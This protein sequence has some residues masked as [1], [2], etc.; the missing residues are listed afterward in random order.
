MQTQPLV[1]L[2]DS[3]ERH[4]A[5]AILRTCVHCGFCNATC[6]TY[7][8]LGDERDGPRGRIYLIKQMLEGTTATRKT[9][10]HLDRCLTCLACETTCPSG[11]AYGSLLD[12]GRAVAEQ[13]VERTFV[14]SAKRGIICAVMPFPRRFGI[15]FRLMQLLAPVMPLNLRRKILAAGS[16]GSAATP[17]QTHAR[18]VLLLDGCVQPILA[19]GINRAAIRV[20]DKLGISALSAPAAGCCGALSYHLSAQ[21]D[22][23]D[24]MRRNIDAWLPYLDQ[25][26]EAIV[27]T[28]SGCGLMVKDY[29]K[30]LKHDLLYSEKAA[31]IS[32][33]SK[34]IAELLSAE[35]LSPLKADV[36][37]TVAYQ[38]PCTLQHGQKLNGV[39]ETLLRRL[40]FKLTAV[41]DAHLCCGSAGAYSLLQ[42]ELSARLLTNKLK[43]LEHEHPDVIATANIGCLTHIQSMTRLPVR[44]WIEMLDEALPD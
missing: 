34:D 20:L 35:D 3:A 11:V 15:V 38:S 4:E 12:I 19:P 2:I 6:P 41:A 13:Q 27:M 5:E 29:G 8:L 43:A 26:L 25:G 32:A 10:Q 39:V 9:Q 18:R 23:L 36:T 37:F 42:P 28:A 40:G 7:Q 21:Q 31:R 22:G 44:H 24:F 30:K 16:A 1:S 33:S 17:K 14:E